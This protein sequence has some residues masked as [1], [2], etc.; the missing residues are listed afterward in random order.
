MRRAAIVVAV[1]V[2]AG[3]VGQKVS[4]EEAAAGAAAGADL[5][6]PSAHNPC[7]DQPGLWPEDVKETAYY[8][9]KWEPARLL[10]WARVGERVGENALMDPKNWLEY[11]P[12]PSG[13][14]VASGKPATRPPDENTDILFPDSDS[15][16]SIGT[17]D[18]A[19]QVRHLTVGANASMGIS[20]MEFCGNVWVRKGQWGPG[21]HVNFPLAFGGKAAFARNDDAKIDTFATHFAVNKPKGGSIEFLGPWD[22]GDELH[23]NSGTMILG[24]GSLFSPADRATHLVFPEGTLVLM[25]GATFLPKGN[26]CFGHDLVVSGTLQAGTPERPLKSD[27]VLALGFKAHGEFDASLPQNRH[28]KNMSTPNDSGLVINPGARLVVY[29]ADP[30]KARLVFR[31]TGTESGSTHVAPEAPLASIKDVPRRIAMTLLGQ[32][33]F[34]GVE[35]N[36]VRK[37]GIVLAHPSINLHWKN[38]FYGENNGGRS[39]VELYRVDDK[40]EAVPLR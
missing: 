40:P 31:W 11:P 2:L 35:F 32:I 1:L 13:S 19:L 30:A 27:C 17:G 24:P 7:F 21:L 33:D 4:A 37:G 28:L 22:V 10:V 18:I 9:Q 8:Q 3:M 36:D 16:Y 25:S 26:K 29:S 15:F 5:K 14:A 39:L 38:L 20:R 12:S 34:N 23:V 6:A